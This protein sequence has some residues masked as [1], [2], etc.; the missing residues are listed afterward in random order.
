MLEP[1]RYAFQIRTKHGVTVDNLKIYGRNETEAR[2]KLIKMYPRCEVLEVNVTA[3]D[4][5]LMYKYEDVLN[6]ITAAG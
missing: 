1:Q 6:L 2:L 5:V 4:H 3:P